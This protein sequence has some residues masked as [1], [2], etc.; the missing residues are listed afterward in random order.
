MD[1]VLITVLDHPGFTSV[2]FWRRGRK[3]DVIK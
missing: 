3:A 2:P 1:V